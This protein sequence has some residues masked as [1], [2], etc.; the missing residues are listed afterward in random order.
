MYFMFGGHNNSS[1]GR[2]STLWRWEGG[3]FSGRFTNAHSTLIGMYRVGG[4]VMKLK[5][6]N[7]MVCSGRSLTVVDVGLIGIDYKLY[8]KTHAAIVDVI[9]S[10]SLRIHRLLSILPSRAR[11]RLRAIVDT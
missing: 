1:S 7:K 2:P 9:E 4:R 8:H 6:G 3:L 11:C 10:T 5:L